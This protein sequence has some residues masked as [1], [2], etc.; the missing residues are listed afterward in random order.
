[1]AEKPASR[2]RKKAPA[3]RVSPPSSARTPE[4]KAELARTTAEL[5]QRNAEL[6]VIN[7]IQQGIAG[8]LSFQAIVELVGDRLR[9]VLRIDTIGI[10]WYDQATRTAHFLYEIERG[11]RVT[12]APVTVSE[13]R[14]KQVTSDRSVIV[15]NTAAEVAAAGTVPG[16]EC[17][18]SSLTVKIVS[19]NRVVGVVIVESFEREYAFGDN[20]IRLL[21]TIVGSMGVALENVRLFNE[22]K[23]ALEQ[24]T[25]TADILKV[26]SESPT[27]V[28]PVFDAIAER[29]RVLCNAIVSGVARLDGDRV[30]LVAYHG[31][32]REA[33]EAMRSAFPMQVSGRT[34][35][36]RAIR[37]R[38]PVQIADV[39]ADPDY[40]AKE[41]ARLAGY[42]SN[43]AVPM[44]RE[45]KVIGSIAV[46]RAEVGPFPEKQVKLL[47]TFADQAVI[48]IE[49][50]RL[51]NETKE[52]LEQQTATAEILRV[53]SSSPADVQP[54]FE[55]IVQGG[56]KLFP[57][58]A[59]AVALPEAGEVRLAAIA[60]ADPARVAAWRARFPFP[61]Q[62]DYM[63]GAAILDGTLIDVSD[64]REAPPG[65]EVGCKNFLQSGYRAATMI[66]MMRGG[67]AI[68]AI[69]VLRLGPGALSAKQLA[70]L[71]TFADQAVIAIENVRLFN[72]TREALEQQTA[73]AEVLQRD[74]RIADRRAAGP[75]RSGAAGAQTLRRGPVGDCAC[76][77]WRHPVRC[78]TRLDGDSD[79]RGDPARPGARDRPRHSGPRSRPHR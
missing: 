67:V 44:L 76:R 5:E 46:C 8:S 26:I 58:A 4:L 41:A 62:R 51:F 49:N 36:A 15:R 16:T 57:G 27:D 64:A 74:Q 40:G 70:L 24:R 31:V 20:E 17:S 39:L 79:R 77:A 28:Q 66:P 12:M 19:E 22:T 1:M 50:I 65:L 7:S 37:E 60:E 13:A 9:E 52:A 47:Q 43:M 38:A 3:S 25:A 54:V 53:I 29:A 14:W 73:T 2:R 45:G 68:G 59:I 10:R 69:D 34:I 56:L 48:A 11:T 42:R 30:H 23:E 71:K 61:L 32:S 35:T 72:E 33:D 63:H 75:R 18:L 55:A 78:W 6:A 21:Q